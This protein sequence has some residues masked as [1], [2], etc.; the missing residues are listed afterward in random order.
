[1]ECSTNYAEESD[2]KFITFKKTLFGKE[3]FNK[4]YKQLHMHYMIYCNNKLVYCCVPEAWV[5]QI[6]QG[7]IC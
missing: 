7:D 5:Q 1:M 6:G 3:K 4:R 2:N